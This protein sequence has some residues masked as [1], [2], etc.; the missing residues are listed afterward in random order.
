MTAAS[1]STPPSELATAPL[2]ALKRPEASNAAT[3]ATTA[4]SA[5]PPLSRSSH[6]SSSA[7]DRVL[8]EPSKVVGRRDSPE[9][10]GPAVNHDRRREQ[11]ARLRS[12]ATAQF[13]GLD[14]LVI[15]ARLLGA[16]T[17]TARTFPL[18]TPR[19][20]PLHD[21]SK[22]RYKSRRHQRDQLAEAEPEPPGEI[23][24]GCQIEDVQKPMDRADD[25]D[26]GRL[27]GRVLERDPDEH[28]HEQTDADHVG[29]DP[30]AKQARALGRVQPPYRGLR[31]SAAWRSAR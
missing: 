13:L 22:K 29:H 16:R 18:E 28:E 2:P 31:S 11:H 20:A 25:V 26:D 23:D 17:F 6:A 10:P 9:G 14:H 24:D 7:A 27:S 8:F 4:S 19:R 1:V 21:K 30:V 3:A 5:E 15:I 12:G